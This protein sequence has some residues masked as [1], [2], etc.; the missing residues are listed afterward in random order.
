MIDEEIF[1]K[2]GKISQIIQGIREAIIHRQI[3]NKFGGRK[4]DIFR[5][6]TTNYALEKAG[7]VVTG[8]MAT[9]MF[10][11]G[12]VIMGNMTMGDVGIINPNLREPHD[13]RPLSQNG[14]SSGQGGYSIYHNDIMDELPRVD[15]AQEN[16]VQEKVKKQEPKYPISDKLEKIIMAMPPRKREKNRDSLASIQGGKYPPVKALIG[17]F[18]WTHDIYFAAE[19]LSLLPPDERVGLL[20]EVM[21]Y[22]K[23]HFNPEE[24]NYDF[25]DKWIVRDLNWLADKGIISSDLISI[26]GQKLRGNQLSQMYVPKERGM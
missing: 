10:D 5:D 12:Q 14:Q 21:T 15:D 17:V 13:D 16:K 2:L 3:N 22:Y 19:I 18:T 1:Q 24:D 8:N 20:T 7:Q 11:K 4:S 23:H 26:L 6:A 25:F 9:D